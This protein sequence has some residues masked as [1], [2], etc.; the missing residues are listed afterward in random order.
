MTG[1]TRDG[2]SVATPLS[3]SLR[4]A[5]DVSVSSSHAGGNGH[6]GAG[7]ATGGGFSSARG[8]ARLGWFWRMNWVMR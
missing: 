5:Q 8:G 4:R 1:E 2:M 6:S 3:M 7:T